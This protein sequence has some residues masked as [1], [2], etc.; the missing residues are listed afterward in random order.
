V[1]LIIW[2]TNKDK[3]DKAWLN[4]QA[5]EALNFQILVAIAYVA[6]MILAFIIIG[7]LL[8]PVV[9][10]ANLIFCILAGMAANK[11]ENYRY[12]VSLRLIK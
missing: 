12:P 8:M 11:G 9:W 7:G 5:V 1:P 10:I 6:C 4:T 2:L 3:T